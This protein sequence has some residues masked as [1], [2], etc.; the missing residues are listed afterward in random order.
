M[1][2]FFTREMILHV[3]TKK[4][5]YLFGAASSGVKV[6]LLLQSLGFNKKNLSFID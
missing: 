4:K 3:L 5:I 1:K 6:A 2:K